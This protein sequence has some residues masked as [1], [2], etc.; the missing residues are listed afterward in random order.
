MNCCKTPGCGSYAINPHLYGREAGADLDLCD[1]CYWRSRALMSQSPAPAPAAVRFVNGCNY[2]GRNCGRSACERECCA[3]RQ[4][5]D[6]SPAVGVPMTDEQIDALLF[7][8][9]KGYASE[10]HSAASVIQLEAF[11][12]VMRSIGRAPAW[13]PM[14]TAPKDGTAILVLL[15]ASD[16]PHA[17][18]WDCAHDHG[19]LMTWDNHRLS[20]A[21]G[22]RYWMPCPDDP[23]EAKPPV[24]G[25]ES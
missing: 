5:A 16:V 19:W 15:E 2:G 22:P 13:R 1:V 4:K 21:D 17:V 18:R 23:D 10:Y 12:R 24:Q 7:D 25:S 14:R 6:A 8:D 20:A 11:H 9:E 3:P